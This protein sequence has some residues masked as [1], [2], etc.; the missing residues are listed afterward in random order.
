MIQEV[1]T[2]MIIGAAIAMAISRIIKKFKGKKQPQKKID[3]QKESFSYQH[4]C[5][6]CSAECML[7]NASQ[8]VVKNNAELCKQIESQG[9]L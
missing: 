5:S 8:T 4:D 3:Y 1:V 2:Y 7:R 6:S 9:K